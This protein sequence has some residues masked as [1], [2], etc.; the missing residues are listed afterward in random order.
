MKN[1]LHNRN[2]KSLLVLITRIQRF[3]HYVFDPVVGYKTISHLLLQVSSSS[4]ETL[5][6]QLVSLCSETLAH[7]WVKKMSAGLSCEPTN[8][9]FIRFRGPGDI[10]PH[11]HINRS[12]LLSATVT[13]WLLQMLMSLQKLGGK[14]SRP[15]KGKN[16][17]WSTSSYCN[18]SLSC[19]LNWEQQMALWSGQLVFRFAVYH[20]VNHVLLLLQLSPGLRH[21]LLKIVRNDGLRHG[22]G[23]RRKAMRAGGCDEA[24][25]PSSVLRFWSLRLSFILILNRVEL[26]W[27]THAD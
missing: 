20:R 10:F 3:S 17:K 24:R 8:Q 21:E 1:S 27:V 22:S 16:L 7:G 13:F 4:C 19:D 25:A 23:A 18:Q 26:S 6:L 5:D 11:K 15:T 9:L 12:Y 14:G 2:H